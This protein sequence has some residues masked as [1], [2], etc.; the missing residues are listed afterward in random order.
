MRYFISGIVFILLLSLSPLIT[1]DEGQTNN[2]AAA[3]VQLSHHLSSKTYGK[4]EYYRLS[5]KANMYVIYYQWV[6]P[7]PTS[8]SR[9]MIGLPDPVFWYGYENRGFMDITINGISSSSVEPLS[10]KVWNESEKAGI[11]TL[12]NFDG[13]KLTLR[14]YMR[15]DSPVLWGEII[16]EMKTMS[17][18]DLKQMRISFHCKPS[19]VVGGQLKGIYE[20]ELVMPGRTLSQQIPSR[21]HP[22]TPTDKYIIFTDLKF[23]PSEK[24]T[25]SQ[26]P[27][28]L[29][30]DWTGLNSGKVW[31]GNEYAAHAELTINPNAEKFSFGLFESKKRYTNR[32]FIEMVKTQPTEFSFK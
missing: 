32:D 15:S 20:R 18:S 19:M 27:C 16:P 28:F 5:N 2:P 23:Q 13:V 8:E 17:E 14:F 4:A 12:F 26:G 25:K 9:F 10:T 3:Q 22:L 24:D 6:K 1:A 11:D 7:S 30:M 31:F 21:W 29:T